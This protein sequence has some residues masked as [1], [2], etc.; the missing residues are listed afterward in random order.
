MTPRQQ[1]AQG[2]SLNH[3]VIKRSSALLG[4]KIRTYCQSRF[5]TTNPG[6]QIKIFIYGLIL[7]QDTF[8]YGWL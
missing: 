1:G 6:N 3:L 8:Q 5:I 7:M 2:I 4:T